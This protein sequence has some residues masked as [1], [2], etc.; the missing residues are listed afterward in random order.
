MEI[1]RCKRK[2][3]NSPCPE[4]ICVSTENIV[5]IIWW[6][7]TNKTFRVSRWVRD[8]CLK[9]LSTAHTK[10]WSFTELLLNSNTSNDEVTSCCSSRQFRFFLHITLVLIVPCYFPPVSPFPSLYVIEVDSWCPMISTNLLLK[11]NIFSSRNSSSPQFVLSRSICAH[12]RRSIGFECA[13]CP[14]WTHL[15]TVS[16]CVLF[17]VSDLAEICLFLRKPLSI[18]VVPRGR[19]LAGPWK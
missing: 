15:Q 19:S 3:F 9:P 11:L 5:M 7:S 1:R 12:S 18:F 8:L 2:S 4:Q 14:I 16:L 10:A 17:R 13:S 6:I